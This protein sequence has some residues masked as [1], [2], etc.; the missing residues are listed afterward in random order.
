MGDYGGS[1]WFTRPYVLAGYPQELVASGFAAGERVDATV[2]ST[3]LALPT[4]TAD[5]DGV[6]RWVFQVPADFEP[7][8]HTGVVVGESET[9]T[10]QAQFIVLTPTTL[11]ALNLTPSPARTVS[12]TPSTTAQVVAP[13]ISGTLAATG[14]DSTVG[15]A[16]G[17]SGILVACGAGL[18]RLRSRR[19]D[20]RAGAR[21]DA[22][23]A[24][25]EPPGGAAG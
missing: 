21:A 2:H 3:P 17:C 14:A 7:G 16:A 12:S 15:V 6:A 8:T 4:A 22:R 19:A 20:A 5:A 11:A 23:A 24:T 18:L 10:A 13:A 25:P 9:R 1:A